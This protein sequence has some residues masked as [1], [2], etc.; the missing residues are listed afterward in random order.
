LKRSLST[1]KLVILYS[2]CKF[3]EK[4]VAVCDDLAALGLKE[5]EK[6]QAES[7]D[8]FYCIADAKQQ[9]KDQGVKLIDKFVN[10]KKRVMKELMTI[11]DTDAQ[12]AKIATMRS[13][14]SDLK[15][16]LLLLEMQLVDQLEE[17]N[18]DFERNMTEMMAGFIEG[19]QQRFTQCRD[20]ENL[21]HEKLTE[22]AM[23]LLDERAKGELEEELP[24]ELRMLFVDKDTIANAINSS[25]DAHT[26]AIDNKEDSII[27]RARGELNALVERV[28]RT[29]AERNRARIAEV[30]SFVS[31][32]SDDIDA[33]EDTAR[34]TQS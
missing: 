22:L 2:A 8:F 19:A 14:L 7:E 27:S 17:V 12:D 4:F 25:H 3:R 34:D 23:H 15:H 1:K 21:H 20:F 26:L 29:E 10:F 5:Y 11:F 28:H 32:H 31:H 6:R 13:E 18:K 30:L 9:N 16:E 24:D 33:Y